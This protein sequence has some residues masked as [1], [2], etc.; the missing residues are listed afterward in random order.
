M[1]VKTTHFSVPQKVLFKHC[2]PAGIVFYPRYLEMVNDAVEA[3]FSDLIEWPFHVMHKSHGAPTVALEASFAAPSRHGD[4]LNLN[5]A[6]E[7]LGTSSLRLRIDAFCADELRFTVLN[8]LVCI[9]SE[10]QSTPWPADVRKRIEAI[11]EGA[12]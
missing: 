3:L 5:I 10:G 2:D 8:T 9:G 1:P 12:I 11:V 6:I 4:E 7:K